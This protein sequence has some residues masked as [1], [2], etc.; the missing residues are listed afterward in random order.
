MSRLHHYLSSGLCLL[1]VG[2][3]VTSACKVHNPLYCD[4][5][6]PC[7]EA[8]RTFC[9]LNGEFPASDGIRNTCIAVP[10]DAAVPD[11][12]PIDAAPICDYRL[13]FVS[14][15]SGSPQLYW[16]SSTGGLATVLTDSAA[17]KL[18]PVW[19]ADGQWLYFSE[20]FGVGD[21][22]YFRTDI[23]RVSIAGGEPEVV[24]TTA[25]NQIGSLSADGSRLYFTSDRDGDW[26]LFATN[27]DGSG[28][29]QLTFNN[30]DD[31]EV[32]LSPN[33]DKLAF[34]RQI[35]DDT[36]I[37]SAHIDGTNIVDF[38][39]SS[40]A[41]FSPRWSPGGGKIAFARIYMANE[42]SLFV[43]NVDGTELT[44]VAQID[45]SSLLYGFTYSFAP[46]GEHLVYEESPDVNVSNIWSVRIDGT[47]LTNLTNSAFHES[48]PTWSPDS[49]QIVYVRND[50]IY[51][52]NA[53]GSG[54]TNLTDHPA[55]DTAP[56]FS[57]CLPAQ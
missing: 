42:F 5:R 45:T 16:M 39:K 38:T 29:A 6:T 49:E 21:G 1:I 46:D 31:S 18:D 56:A 53:D 33:G 30:D 47:G 55:A 25:L 52:M 48:F 13:A 24:A 27:P 14:D 8:G 40:F 19:S 44:E 12:R 57:S 32:R 15:R 11:A 17:D 28:L 20:G 36:D 54:Q 50:D 22:D 10:V 3:G 51:V 37:F 2:V 26:E 35:A 34:S 43:M 4:D 23:L 9:D 7:S 41:E